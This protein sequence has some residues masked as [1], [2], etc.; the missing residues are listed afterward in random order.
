[1]Q[2]LTNSQLEVIKLLY[3]TAKTFI[4]VVTGY[5]FAFCGAVGYLWKEQR[6][7][8]QGELLNHARLTI[9]LGVCSVGIW[10]GTI[11]FCI[12]TVAFSDFSLINYGQ[13]CAQIGHILFFLSVAT[14]A[15]MALKLA[16]AFRPHKLHNNAK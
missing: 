15:L 5:L 12:R 10:S 9:I 8:L 16:N 11:P 6:Q 3:D 4:P 13:K 7:L 14:G 1:M 2:E